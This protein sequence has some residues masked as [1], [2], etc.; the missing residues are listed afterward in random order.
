[1]NPEFCELHAD[2]RTRLSRCLAV[3]RQLRPQLANDPDD[4]S[5]RMAEILGAGAR[6]TA[7]T[8]GDAVVALAVWRVLEKTF[9]GR[10]LYVDDLV[11]DAERRSK[12]IGAKLI[13]HLA[14]QARKLDCGLLALDSSTQRHAAHRFYLHE[15][16]SIVGF[17]F[18]RRP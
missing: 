8:H 9:C 5:R 11:T 3:H 7:A 10:E 13:A 1:M 2:D 15:G 16:F 4:Y 18:T 17:R 14:A 12:G 6:M